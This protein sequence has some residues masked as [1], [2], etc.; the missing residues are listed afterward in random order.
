VAGLRQAVQVLYADARQARNLCV[1]ED[2]LTRFD[3]HHAF[4]L[5]PSSNPDPGRAPEG[6]KSLLIFQGPPD[7]IHKTY[8]T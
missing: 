3:L 4:A 8:N 7:S 6:A 1:R 2:L 5:N